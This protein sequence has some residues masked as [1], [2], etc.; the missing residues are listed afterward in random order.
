LLLLGYGLA[1]VS[2]PLFPLADSMLTVFTARLLDRIG[3]GIRGAPRDALIAD[4][5]PANI[6]GTCFGLRQSMDTL[7]AF[8]GPLTAI[9]LLLLLNGDMQ[10]VLWV[11][12]IPA[13]IALLLIVVYVEEPADISGVNQFH[14]PLKWSVLKRFPRAYWWV[15]VI[16]AF[17]TLARF[18]EA[19][20][21][22]RAQQM[23]LPLTWIPMVMVVMSL[24][25]ALS[26]YPAGILSDRWNKKYLLAL[27][28]LWLILADFIL[29]QTLNISVLMLG[30]ALWGLHMGFSQ[31]ILATLIAESTPPEFKGTGFGLFN[32]VSGVLM[33]LASLIA[34]WLWDSAGA[35]FT[36]Y[37]GAGFAFLAMIL[38]A[39]KQR[40]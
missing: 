29:A 34:G 23:G 4:L 10:L 7:G 14:S 38:L 37:C 32:F 8:M 9:L 21:V 30:V 5:A 22:L 20:L 6:R 12:V 26:A 15:V 33:L 1:A 11:A 27:S 17:F 3:K 25:Y 19:F 24:S 18:S 13:F 35:E 28:L 2:K 40:A 39:V 16:G 36:F 31:G